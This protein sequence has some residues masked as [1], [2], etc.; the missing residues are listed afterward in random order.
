MELQLPPDLEELV[1]RQIAAKRYDTPLEVLRAALVSLDL[2]E[3][4]DPEWI[5][6]LNQKIE[7]GLAQ[8]DRGEGIP[9]DE[10]FDRIR[11]RV[12]GG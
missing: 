10:A 6:E 12:L 11:R 4:S 2:Q 8:L 5:K 1:R 9:G 7:A 3:T